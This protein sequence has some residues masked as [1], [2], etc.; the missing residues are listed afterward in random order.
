MCRLGMTSYIGA[1]WRLKRTAM[2]T[3]TM[4]G[5]PPAFVRL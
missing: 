3:S 2:S 4:D 5:Y 1:A